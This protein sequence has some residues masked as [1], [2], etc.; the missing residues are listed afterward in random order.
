MCDLSCP[1][2]TSNITASDKI[3]LLD[4][5]EMLQEQGN[6]VI[7][8]MV[9]TAALVRAG[10]RDVIKSNL[11]DWLFLKFTRVWKFE[12]STIR[13]R[14]NLE[15]SYRL[16][17]VYL[18]AGNCLVKRL[19]V[20]LRNI[21]RKRQLGHSGIFKWFI[22]SC[23]FLSLNGRLEFCSPRS[24]QLSVRDQV[25]SFMTTSLSKLLL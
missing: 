12:S 6:F 17:P 23:H 2:G 24:L 1:Q 9:F 8:V 18:C 7:F 5:N 13:H 19:Y 14:Q 20:Q 4:L 10:P 21:P 25:L 11:I 15:H 16:L 22:C 3:I